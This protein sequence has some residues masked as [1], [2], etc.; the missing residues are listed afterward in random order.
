MCFVVGLKQAEN[1]I[2]EIQSILLFQAAV[3]ELS[4]GFSDIDESQEIVW[5]SLLDCFCQ[6]GKNIP[7]QEDLAI[8]LH[9]TCSEIKSTGAENVLV[10]TRT[11]KSSIGDKKRSPGLL[12]DFCLERYGFV[13]GLNAASPIEKTLLDQMV[14]T[15]NEFLQK[16]NAPLRVASIDRKRKSR[17]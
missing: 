16:D 5:V 14:E 4:K 17:K 3:G 12:P 6:R 1:A 8:L 2:L 11:T 13:E 15:S 9:L 7:D 10:I